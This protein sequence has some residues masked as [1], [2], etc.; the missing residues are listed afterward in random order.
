MADIITDDIRA[1][2]AGE[3]QY[4]KELWPKGQFEERDYDDRSIEEWVLYMEAYISR[5]RNEITQGD[6]SAALHTIRKITTMGVQCMRKHGVT[7]REGY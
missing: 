1:A 5:A 6:P 2:L 3:D 7:R 4:Q